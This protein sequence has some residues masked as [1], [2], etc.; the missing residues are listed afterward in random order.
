M[1]KNSISQVAWS[2]LL[3]GARRVNEEQG[4]GE[5]KLAQLGENNYPVSKGE[6]AYRTSFISSY[7]LPPASLICV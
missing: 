5:Q 6:K 4:T 3:S 7:L 1:P 2:F